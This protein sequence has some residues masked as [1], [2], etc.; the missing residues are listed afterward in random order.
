[1]KKSTIKYFLILASSL[2]FADAT[3]DFY[4][5]EAKMMAKENEILSKP[6]TDYLDAL[7]K[8]FN[9]MKVELDLKESRIQ[10]RLNAVAKLKKLSPLNA[11]K[12]EAL[13]REISRGQLVLLNSDSMEYHLARIIHNLV[14][15]TMIKGKNN[16]DP[17]LYYVSG[18]AIFHYDGEGESELNSYLSL[19]K[20]DKK[21]KEESEELIRRIKGLRK[22]LN[23]ASDG[24]NHYLD[25]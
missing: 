13:L 8:A 17:K 21:L 5:S 19:G 25:N 10:P 11:D 12:L 22:A 6:Q 15:E 9:K 7:D 4:V 23:E 14:D 16:I 3:G 18:R 20:E 24:R 1:M 2:S